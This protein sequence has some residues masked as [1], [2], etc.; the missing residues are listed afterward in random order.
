MSHNGWSSTYN[1][2]GYKTPF[3]RSGSPNPDCKAD[4]PGLNWG[5]IITQDWPGRG[6]MTAALQPQQPLVWRRPPLRQS[7]GLV[8][9]KIISNAKIRQ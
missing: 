3:R 2:K 6:H 8:K 1:R 4:L 7:K 9:Y 5:I